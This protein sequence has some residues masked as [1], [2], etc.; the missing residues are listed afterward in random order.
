M[1][2][3][4]LDQTFKLSPCN[5]FSSSLF[6]SCIC[7]QSIES[8]SCKLTAQSFLGKFHLVRDKRHACSR[9]FL[10]PAGN[11]ASSGKFVKGLQSPEPIRPH[12]CPWMRTRLDFYS[13][14]HETGQLYIH[15]L[16]FAPVPATNAQ[17]WIPMLLEGACLDT[18]SLVLRNLSGLMP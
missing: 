7:L 10:C 8:M 2:T 13:L 5:I 1:N 11:A 16:G 4:Q 3:D 6:K 15:D 9:K 12:E 18:E 17:G 14:R